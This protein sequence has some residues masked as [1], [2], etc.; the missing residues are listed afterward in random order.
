[1]KLRFLAILVFLLTVSTIA[2]SPSKVL[3]QAEKALGGPK[4][5]TQITSWRRSGT[6][7][8]VSDGLKGKIILQT[9]R[10]NLYNLSIDIDGFEIET[11]FNGKSGW[12]RDSRNGLRTLTGDAS[13]DFQAEAAFQNS[14]WLN[15]KKDKA[16]IVRGGKS[17]VA[18]KPADVVTI[19]TAKGSTIKLF[20]DP[21]SSLPVREEFASG[22]SVRVF[23]FSDY[24]PVQGVRQPHRVR[25]ELDGNVYEAVFDEIRANQR[26]ARTEFDFP[27]I[28]NEPLPDVPTLLKEL[29]ANEDKVEELLETYSYVQKRTSREMREDGV[30]RDT[31][32][33]TYQLSFYKGYRIARLIEKDGKPLSANEQADADRDAEKRVEEIDK[34]IAKREANPDKDFEKGRR[35]SIAEV[36]RASTLSNPRRERFRG[37][38]VIVFDFE[39]NPSFDL[40]NA[41]SMLKLFGKVAGAMWIDEKDKQ[42]ARLEGF[43][44]DSYKIGGGMVAKL[45]KSSSFALEQERINDEIWLPSTVDINVSVRVFLVKGIDLNAVIKT[46][47]YRKF[48]TEVKDAK[49]NPIEQP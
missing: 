18:G 31:G 6:I 17:E 30:L 48:K 25:I 16:K 22:D 40:K 2:Q 35:V 36:L 39:P 1:M 29:Q 33:Q 21:Q 38:D 13:T 12:M 19:N 28:S 49:V 20:V 9:T 27:T 24:R 11:G 44:F 42:V 8:R 43:L 7:T 14:L 37:R 3:K 4:A 26:I 47:D 45:R 5:L 41:R 23:E 15:A 34:L 10:P 32:S 46:Y